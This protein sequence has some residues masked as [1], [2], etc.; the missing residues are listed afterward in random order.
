MASYLPV[1]PSENYYYVNR[2]IF[3]CSVYKVLECINKEKTE[4]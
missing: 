1:I 2:A 3:T 4:R